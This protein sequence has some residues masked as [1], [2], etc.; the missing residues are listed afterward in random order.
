[1]IYLEKNDNN[2]IALSVFEKLPINYLTGTTKAEYLFNF[3]NDATNRQ[4][5]FIQE[6]ILDS[7]RYSLFNINISASTTLNT[8]YYTYRLYAQDS[9]STNTNIDFSGTTLIEVGKVFING[10]NSTINSVYL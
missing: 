1:M 9:G 3:T 4:E 2:K 10:N 7:W 5:S 6:P 8:G